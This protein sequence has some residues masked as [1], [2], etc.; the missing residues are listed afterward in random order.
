MFN[1]LALLAELRY[2]I[3]EMALGSD[4]YPHAR[5]VDYTKAEDSLVLG[6]QSYDA[7]KYH[8]KNT[9]NYNAIAAPPP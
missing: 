3:Y 2:T 7:I 1:L 9:A 6:S 5:W 8:S 4:T